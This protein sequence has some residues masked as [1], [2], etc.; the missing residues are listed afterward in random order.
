MSD[1][2]IKSVAVLGAGT[3]GTG[4]AAAC[5]SAGCKTAMLDLT[6]ELADKG[7]ERMSLGRFPML[8]DPGAADL[9]ATGSFD[10]SFEL[11][12]EA[13]WICEAVIED[14][15]IKRSIFSKSSI[16]ATDQTHPCLLYTSPS[17]RDS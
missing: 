15:E 11:V 16:T 9:I 3:M 2:R 10:E 1:R 5:A 4:I 13:D 14:L 6:K 8:D 7:K 12:A 17:P